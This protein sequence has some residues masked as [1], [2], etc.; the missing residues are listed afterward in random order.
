MQLN[1]DSVKITIKSEK[2]NAKLDVILDKNNKAQR[3]FV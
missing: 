2:F 1:I 3:Y